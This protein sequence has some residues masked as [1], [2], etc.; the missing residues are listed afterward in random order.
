MIKV[1]YMDMAR[2]ALGIKVWLVFEGQKWERRTWVK[3]NSEEIK[4]KKK[5]L[6][7]HADVKHYA[8]K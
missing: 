6:K 1:N 4:Y 2:Y 3:N 5:T 8:G 7:K